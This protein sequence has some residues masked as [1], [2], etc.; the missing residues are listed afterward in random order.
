[1]HVDGIGT[2]ID[3]ANTTHGHKISRGIKISRDMSVI[4][5]ESGEVRPTFAHSF[6]ILLSIFVMF[7]ILT[8]LLDPKFKSLESYHLKPENFYIKK[9]PNK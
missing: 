6:D 4:R 1:M 2:E 3:S 7:R 9:T 5:A 8:Q